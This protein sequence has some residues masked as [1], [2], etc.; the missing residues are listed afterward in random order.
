MS[1]QL[2]GVTTDTVPYPVQ[3]HGLSAFCTGWAGDREGMVYVSFI[4]RVTAV[5]GI[6]AAFMDNNAIRITYGRF[7]LKRPKL[8]GAKY[9]TIRTRLPESDWLHLVV[10]HTQA[11]MH[12][13]PDQ[14]FYI[15]SATTDPPL[16]AFWVQ[17]NNAIAL[18]AFQEWTPL[19]WEKGE[20]EQL[21]VQCHAQG[22]YCWKVNKSAKLW[23]RI[24]N[25]IVMEVQPCHA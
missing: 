4:G 12:N 21:I 8:E 23:G 16:E 22:T 7:L 25:Q 18:P 3:Y 20:Y 19:L 1:N 24:L 15:L 13:L 11:T 2:I 14:N 17:W 10:L 9:H 5:T 6:W